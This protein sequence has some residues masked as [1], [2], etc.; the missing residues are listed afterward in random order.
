MTELTPEEK[1][2]KNYGGAIW[3]AANAFM[4]E[5]HMIPAIYREDVMQEARIAF[6]Q[7]YRNKEAGKFGENGNKYLFSAIRYH[8]YKA[9]INANGVHRNPKKPCDIK[10]VAVDD[11]TPL[12]QP[13]SDTVDDMCE[14]ADLNR[15]MNTL[16]PDDRRVV[17]LMLAGYPPGIIQTKTGMKPYNYHRARQRIGKSYRGYFSE[18]I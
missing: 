13:E 1:L 9:F 7:W 18:A 4:E 15:W 3:Y 6:I 16:C 10:I 17:R 14:H 11:V 2:L 8:L 12:S 5:R